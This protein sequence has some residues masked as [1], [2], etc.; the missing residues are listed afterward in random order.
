MISTFGQPDRKLSLKE[1]SALMASVGEPPGSSGKSDVDSMYVGFRLAQRRSTVPLTQESWESCEIWLYRWARPHVT[2]FYDCK[3]HLSVYPESYA[4]VV[5]GDQAIL[6]SPIYRGERL[7]AVTKASRQG[8]AGYEAQEFTF[9][10]GEPEKTFAASQLALPSSGDLSGD[11]ASALAEKAYGAY[12]DAVAA[13]GGN[14]PDVE[15]TECEDFLDCQVLLYYWSKPEA[16][17][18][19]SP[20]GSPG[21][22]YKYLVKSYIFLQ[23]DNT[24]IGGASIDRKYADRDP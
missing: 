9:L 13:A 1:F 24:I 23:R 22:S 17:R 20:D 6:G 11:V 3:F 14:V 4:F 7:L 12:K 8:R 18:M 15:W 5:S 19:Y 21:E 10:F 2:S 16:G